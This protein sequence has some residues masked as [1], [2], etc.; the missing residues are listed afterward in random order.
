MYNSQSGQWCS[1]MFQIKSRS[2]IQFLSCFIAHLSH[3]VHPIDFCWK[4]HC[5]PETERGA[6]YVWLYSFRSVLA[7]LLRR[8]TEQKD[9][10][11]LRACTRVQC[12]SCYVFLTN[13]ISMPPGLYH[14]G[15][16]RSF[17]P[18]PHIPHI[19]TVR[20]HQKTKF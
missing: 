7:L 18:P 10:N 20:S 9:Y 4:T 5:W 8:R 14:L 11:P 12:H 15:R 17:T 2:E 6:V 1:L 13:R 16:G 19:F 3:F